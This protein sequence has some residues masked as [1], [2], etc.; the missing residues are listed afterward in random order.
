MTK[1]TFGRS[2]FLY[3][4]AAFA[5]CLAPPVWA[6][7]PAIARF[8]DPRPIVVAHRGCWR[9]TA[10]NALSGLKACTE[11][12]IDVVEVDLR[13]TKDGQLV[14][15]HDDTLDRMTNLSGPVAERTLAEFKTARL[16]RADG[17]KDSPITNE[18]PPTFVEE[19]R[20]A[21][22]NV[23][24]Y[25]DIKIPSAQQ[26][27]YRTIEQEGAQ[28]WVVIPTDTTELGKMPDWARRQTILA[29][30]QCGVE[31]VTAGCYSTLAQAVDAVRPFHPLAIGVF[32]KSDDFLKNGAASSSA[33]GT[34]LQAWSNAPIYDA[35]RDEADP[36]SGAGK[37]WGALLQLGLDV[38][39]TDDALGLSA[40]LKTAPRRAAVAWSPACD[41]TRTGKYTFDHLNGS[42]EHPVRIYLCS[43]V[44]CAHKSEFAT[45]TQDAYAAPAP[46]GLPR[47]YFLVE[48]Q[49]EGQATE[50]RVI[51]ARRLALEGAYN[52]RDLGGI[53][54]VDGKWIRWG[55]IF[56]SDGLSKLTPADYSRLNAIGISL[57]C[58]LRTRDERKT[59]PTEWHDGS[60]VFMLAPVSETSKGAPD[61]DYDGTSP[62]PNRSIEDRKAAFERSYVQ[63]AFDS[64]AKFGAVLRAIATSD[65]PS[66]FH[67]AAGRDRTGITAAMLLH[68][69]GVRDETIVSDYLLSTK[70]LEEAERPTP[71]PATEAEAR[72]ARA[73]SEVIRL[74]PRYIESVFKAI[75]QR[76]GSFDTYRRDALHF[77]DAEVAVLKARLLE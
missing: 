35:G 31:G 20:A 33:V 68:I 63:I 61:D 51:G 56:R 60:P 8:A 17:G 13:L 52:F 11:R 46:Q 2:T 38:F 4:W 57:V 73:Y 22:G 65:G 66:V 70:Y 14:L 76:Y 18:A 24:L 25:L 16:R 53:K 26:Q 37:A 55:Q 12:G 9:I 34:R 45:V 5:V 62:S 32:F 71:P 77:T 23:I 40:Y 39:G 47:P 19:L 49:V 59:Y 69:L 28:D 75:D 42:S 3:T 58:D 29:A 7:A 27:I 43:D 64:A 74:Q 67:C 21:K 36:S 48:R 6:A 10:E 15:M 72:E 30:V 44:H 41:E 50:E 54:T 1:N